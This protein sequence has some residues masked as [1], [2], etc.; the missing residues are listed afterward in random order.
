MRLSDK[1]VAIAIVLV[2]VCMQSHTM[3][4][5]GSRGSSSRRAV[6]RPVAPRPNFAPGGSSSRSNIGQPSIP[7]FAF[8]ELFTSEGCSSCPPADE[9]LARLNTKI[10]DNDRIYTLSYHVDYWN[11]LGWE[12][13]Y[14]QSAFTK[15]QR[16]YA[17]AFDSEKVYTPQLVINGAVEFNGSDEQKSDKA[18]ELAL[19]QTPT[20]GI[21]V[22][23]S[24]KKDTV[25]I[26]W[27]VAGIQSNDVISFALV[28]NE[29]RQKVTTGE[30][31]NRDLS[32]INIV[33]KLK[34]IPAK[35][36]NGRLTLDL[37][38]DFV[39]AKF[40]VVAFVQSRTGQIKNATRTKFSAS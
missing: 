21:E 20:A 3:A 15:R 10:E 27:Q 17:T 30:N 11:R 19:Q 28:Q 40:H 25:R 14:S 23:A 38:D 18:V 16:N 26:H 31:A 7:G 39:A 12:D 35:R 34:S 1:L 2:I 33:R 9:N 24:L 13:P 32:H 36:S 6:S 22:R 8:L 29:G 37:P 4:Q 5:S